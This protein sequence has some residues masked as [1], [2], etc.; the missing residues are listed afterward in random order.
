MKLTFEPNLQYQ[1]DAIKSTTGLFEGQP[2]EDSL[3]EYEVKEEGK[4]SLINGIGNH[5]VL[6]GEQVLENL[7]EVQKQNEIPVSSELDGMNFSV[8]M[9]TGT[10]KTYIYLRSIYELNKLYDFKKFVIVVPS[11][12]IREGV[13]KN[14]EITDGHFQN[15]YDKV[16]VNFNVYS[17][18]NLGKA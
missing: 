15:L 18:S 14:L 1:L 10:G 9:E 5:L 16:S 8:E 12:P 7:Q 3:L 11:V 4:L 6:S 2:L 13:L 17:S